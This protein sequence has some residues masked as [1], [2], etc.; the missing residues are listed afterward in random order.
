[1]SCSYYYSWQLR[2]LGTYLLNMV[3]PRKILVNSQSYEIF[4]IY[5]LDILIGDVYTWFVCQ[6]LFFALKI[7]KCVFFTFNYNLLTASQFA[8]LQSSRLALSHNFLISL[9]LINKLVSNN[10]ND[11]KFELSVDREHSLIFLCKVT[12]RET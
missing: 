10:K 8:T 4:T 2:N 7:T 9:S 12:A 5:L 6:L 11:N 3:F 1:M